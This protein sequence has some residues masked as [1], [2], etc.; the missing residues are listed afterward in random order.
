MYFQIDKRL[1]FSEEPYHLEISVDFFNLRLFLIFFVEQKSQNYRHKAQDNAKISRNCRVITII[2][3]HH[4]FPINLV[5]KSDSS[6]LQAKNLC[7]RKLHSGIK[8]SNLENF[9]F[10][11]IVFFEESMK[12]LRRDKSMPVMYNER[13]E[14]DNDVIRLRSGRV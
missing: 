10:F 14:K 6:H 1:F 2:L 13:F 12:S 3:E 9:T 4:W 8:V 5:I 7:D 11:S